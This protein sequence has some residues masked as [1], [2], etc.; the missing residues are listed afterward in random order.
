MSFVC[1]I[2]DPCIAAWSPATAVP[3]YLATGT[4]DGAGLGLGSGGQAQLDL[5]VI[6]ADQLVKVSEF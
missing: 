4:F 3:S 2:E 6:K 5:N 1:G